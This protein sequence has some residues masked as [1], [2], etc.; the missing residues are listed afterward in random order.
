[1]KKRNIVDFGVILLTTLLC[2]MLMVTYGD[3]GVGVSIV[4]YAMMYMFTMR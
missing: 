4:I 1:M 2:W 3:K